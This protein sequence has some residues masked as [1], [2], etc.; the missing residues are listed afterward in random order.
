MASAQDYNPIALPNIYQ[1]ADNALTLGKQ[2]PYSDY[3]QQDVSY[4]IYA[5]IDEKTDIITGK[6]ELIYWNNSPDTLKVVYFHLY[7]N[8]FLPDS[9]CD[10]LHEENGVKNTFGKYQ[11]YGIGYGG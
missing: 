2:E 3:W 6:E 11:S 8:A 4:K 9:Y 5:T 7:Q 10:H 1:S